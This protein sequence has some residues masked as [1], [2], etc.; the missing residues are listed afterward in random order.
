MLSETPNKS[1]VYILRHKPPGE[2]GIGKEA[3]ADLIEKVFKAGMQQ[4]QE[5]CVLCRGGWTIKELLEG[6]GVGYH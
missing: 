6:L 5:S 3:I 2:K 4:K 1:S